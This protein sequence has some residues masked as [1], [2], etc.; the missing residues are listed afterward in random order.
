MSSDT[1]MSMAT[2]SYSSSPSSPSSSSD[3]ENIIIQWTALKSRISHYTTAYFDDIKLDPE[4]LP[5]RLH[6][7]VGYYGHIWLDQQQPAAWVIEKLI[8]TWLNHHIFGKYCFGLEEAED[9][10]LQK[11]EVKLAT[12]E[13]E[14][15]ANLWRKDVISRLVNH[16]DHVTARS[17]RIRSLAV[18]F[19]TEMLPH[20]LEAPSSAD[21]AAELHQ[22]VDIAVK[23]HLSM[24]G[25]LSRFDVVF[26]EKFWCPG[27]DRFHLWAMETLGTMDILDA[28]EG[29]SEAIEMQRAVREQVAIRDRRSME[30]E[31]RRRSAEKEEETFWCALGREAEGTVEADEADETPSWIREM[32]AARRDQYMRELSGEPRG[33]RVAL[34]VSPAIVELKE[35]GRAAFLVK[36]SVCT[37]NF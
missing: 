25:A 18:E 19:E 32:D 13:S 5:Q 35:G 27:S 34:F 20:L 30:E 6:N 15:F 23:V 12:Q 36:A 31:T 4:S 28:G 8:F 2:S 16:Q 22:I 1:I 9:E 17:E 33:E 14:A 29:A 21:R 37:A 10:E 11:W 24:R 26:M 3:I 7:Y